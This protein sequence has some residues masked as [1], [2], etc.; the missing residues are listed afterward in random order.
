MGTAQRDRDWIV[1]GLGNIYVY[2]SKAIGGLKATRRVAHILEQVV[3]DAR[4]I[5]DEVRKFRETVLDILYSTRAH[6]FR[7]VYFIRSPED[8]LVNPVRLLHEALAETKGVK[9]LDTSARNAIG[10]AQ[11]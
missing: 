5:H 4:L 2:R 10:L 9:H 1:T 8:R 3:M 6:D 11:T 7:A